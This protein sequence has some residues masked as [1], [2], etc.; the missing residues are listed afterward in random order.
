MAVCHPIRVVFRGNCPCVR[1]GPCRTPVAPR[2]RLT[3]GGGMRR[4]SGTGLRVSQVS[5]APEKRRTCTRPLPGSGTPPA[6]PGERRCRGRIRR[7]FTHRRLGGI[8]PSPPARKSACLRPRH[9]CLPGTPRVPPPERAPRQRPAVG[10][11]VGTT[12]AGR[13]IPADNG[14]VTARDVP[15]N[16][17][18]PALC[19][20]SWES[21]PGA[22]AA[23]FGGEADLRG[24][25]DSSPEKRRGLDGTLPRPFHPRLCHII[26]KKAYRLH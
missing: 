1:E 22:S 21:P 6:Y 25:T 19:A 12:L 16:H 10:A 14:D 2:R 5:F 20:S 8:P 11:P 7:V 24:R 3:S 18:T 17:T 15:A 4:V 23:L 13:A 9:S 26:G